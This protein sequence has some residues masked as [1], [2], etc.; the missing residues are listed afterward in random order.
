L[1]ASIDWLYENVYP[2]SVAPAAC[3]VTDGESVN[4]DP[5][6]VPAPAGNEVPAGEIHR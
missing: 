4:A 1:I 2:A 6:A 3:Q 5:D